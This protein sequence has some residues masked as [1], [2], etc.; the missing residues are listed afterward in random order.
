LAPSAAWPKKRW[1]LSHWKNLIGL[2]LKQTN[3]SILILGGPKDDFCKDLAALDQKRIV[4]LQGSLTL[5]ESAAAVKLSKKLVV[6][7][8]GLLHMAE[9][10]DIPVVALIGPTPFGYPT[11]N[12]SVTLERDLWCKPCSK[13]G[14]GICWNPTYQKCLVDLKP[15]RVAEHIR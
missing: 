11:K 1:P 3:L 5:L 12:I 15:E 7:D 2:I 4:N 13:D 9:A 14:R 8:T 6:A 10:M